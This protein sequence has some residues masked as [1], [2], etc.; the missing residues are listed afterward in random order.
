MVEKN[1]LVIG[2]VKKVGMRLQV[3]RRA[4]KMYVWMKRTQKV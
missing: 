2:K 3:K 4:W 1:F